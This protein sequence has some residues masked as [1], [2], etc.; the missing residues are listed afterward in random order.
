[1][2]AAATD[3]SKVPALR[4]LEF[5][6]KWVEAELKDLMLFKNG[7]N[8]EKGSY[9]QGRKF[10]NV[11]DII[12]NDYI[13]YDNIIGS[14]DVSDISA[15]NYEVSYGDILF[16]RSSETREDVGQSNVYLDQDRNALFGGFVIRG[17]KNSKY[18]PV[19]L[20]NLL[21]TAHARKEITTKSGGSTRYNVGQE[22]LKSV[23]IF[24]S[25]DRAEQTKIASLLTAV[26]E[27]IQGLLKKK[28]LLTTYKK[29]VMQKLFSQQTRF[30]Q[31]NGT[32]FPDWKEKKA[33]NIFK[34]ISNREHDGKLPILAV[35]QNN[36]V[37]KRDDLDKDIK[38]SANS[39]SSYK[40]IEKGDFVI[41]L[42]SFQGGIE[43]S[44]ITGI[45]SPA[46]TVL[47]PCLDIS[48]GFYKYL[49]K[50]ELFINQLSS[51]VIG[52]RDGKQISYSVFSSLV[53]PYPSP[54][55]QKKIAD[56]LSAIDDKIAAISSQ[57]DQV[58]AFK[59]ALLQQMFI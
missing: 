40:I 17:K 5:K 29:G 37:M 11:M 4:F 52:I 16:Q 49:F 9:G 39:I 42:R 22:T 59:K 56:F 13:L 47:K 25:S 44:H 27:R 32:P 46:Y 10:I 33:G 15:K 36:G 26:D 24:I 7:I 1:M 48:D 43:Y 34:N 50:K 12:S 30:T 28:D 23:R 18:D 8:A 3:K 45:S 21:K 58:K 41:S 19:Y 54:D 55:E 57:V 51:A 35:T 38:T 20:N 14:V 31:N 53:L 6:E 2:S